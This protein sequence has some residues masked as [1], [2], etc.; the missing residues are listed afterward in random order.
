MLLGYA[1]AVSVVGCR[2]LRR[3]WTSRAPRAAVVGWQALSTSVVSAILLA[4]VSLA[5]PFL[6]LRFS[7]ASLLGAHSVAIIE[8]YETPVGVWPGI[9]G[10]AVVAGLAS[11]LVVTTGR[12][13]LRKRRVRRSQLASLRLVGHPHPDG[14]TVI[15]H[16]VPV[17]YCLPGGSGTVVLSSAALKLL[18]PRERELVLAH[19]RSHLRARH[20]LALAYSDALARTFP[21]VPLFAVAHDHV[22]TLLEMA[23][24]DAAA[25]ARD[26]R[27]LAVALVA[28]GTG[29]RPETALA[30]SNT[31]L[32][33]R[34]RR[35]TTISASTPRG[36]GFLLS[37]TAALVLSAPLGLALA[38]A[39]EAAATDCCTLATATLRR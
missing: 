28:L 16:Q 39:I 38:P 22:A 2:V 26:R 33:Q 30:A 34:V 18:D 1:V 31:A 32:L 5:L 23:A 7:L 19:E 9:L 15:D 37:T 6:P 27:R 17:A 36:T 35:L 4:A 3:S 11:M 8:H 13:F 20:D 21:W 14:F 25:G 29:V 10:L 12:S 24:D